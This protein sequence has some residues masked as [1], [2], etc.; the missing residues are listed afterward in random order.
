[1]VKLVFRDIGRCRDMELAYFKGEFRAFDNFNLN[2][3]DSF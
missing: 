1:L 2:N 3:E